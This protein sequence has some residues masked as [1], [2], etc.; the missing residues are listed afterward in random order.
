MDRDGIVGSDKEV[1]GA[2]AASTDAAKPKAADVKADHAE[3]KQPDA[4]GANDAVRD[5][6]ATSA[7]AMTLAGL[8]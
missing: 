5:A 3:D 1:K 2:V 4:G 6:L 7:A 8:H